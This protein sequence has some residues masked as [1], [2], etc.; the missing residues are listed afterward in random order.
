MAPK[1]HKTAILKKKK[2]KNFNDVIKI[3]LF[4]TRNE[5]DLQFQIINSIHKKKVV[6]DKKLS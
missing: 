6:G 5:K 4:C 2:T 1:K 3:T